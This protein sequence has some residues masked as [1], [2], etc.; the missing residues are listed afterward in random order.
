VKNLLASNKA[1]VTGTLVAAKGCG[2][3]ALVLSSFL[4]YGGIPGSSTQP[5]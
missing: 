1:N 5:G 2:V 3:P 4:I